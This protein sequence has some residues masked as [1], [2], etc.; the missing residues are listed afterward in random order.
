MNQLLTSAFSS[1]RKTL[2]NALR[3]YLDEG[4]L[5]SLDINPRSR[6]EN[7]VPEDFIRCVNFLQK[8]ND[9]FYRW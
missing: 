7:L 6:P 5:K 4:E 8:K 2:K 1:R 9:Y 3:N